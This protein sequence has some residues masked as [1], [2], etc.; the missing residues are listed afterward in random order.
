MQRSTLNPAWNAM[1]HVKNVPSDGT[2]RV[3]LYDKDMYVPI[4]DYIGTLHFP[5]IVFE[6]IFFFFLCGAPCTANADK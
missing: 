1:W 2:L 5:P 3:T 6:G 4:D